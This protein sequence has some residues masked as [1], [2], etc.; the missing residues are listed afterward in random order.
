M[1]AIGHDKTDLGRQ[2]PGQAQVRRVGKNVPQRSTPEQTIEAIDDRTA[3]SGVSDWVADL[4]P[5]LTYGAVTW[6][7]LAAL[8]DD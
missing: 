5:H 3:G 1:P 2:L 6:S 8:Q 4:L 7:V